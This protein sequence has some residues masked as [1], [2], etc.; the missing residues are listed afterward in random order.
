MPRSRQR[1]QKL[2]IMVVEDDALIGMLLTEMLE[3][4]GHRVCSVAVNQRDAVLS[5]QKYRPDFM[6]VDSRLRQ[7][8]GIETVAE[9]LRSGFIPHAFVTG[10]A[11]EIRSLNP[12]AVIIDKPFREQD[13]RHGIER[14]LQLELSRL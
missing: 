4:M 5:A 12:H 9:I 11:A 1:D 8:C 10:D 14:A 2:W 3:S 6:L 13:L 7:G